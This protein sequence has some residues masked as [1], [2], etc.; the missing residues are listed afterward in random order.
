MSRAVIVVRT[1]NR[2]EI[3][4]RCLAAL[5]EGC[6][7]ARNAHWL[8]LDDSSPDGCDPTREVAR[9]WRLFG[10]RLAYVDKAVEAEIA[11]SLP[12]ALRGSFTQLAARS[13]S[14]RCEGGRNLGLLAGL[15]L[16]PEVV[17]FV[18]DDMVHRHQASCFLHWCANSQHADSFVAAPRKHGIRDMNY[19]NRLSRILEL[20]DWAQFVSSIGI[21]SDSE[22]WY[23][24]RNPFWKC[25]NDAGDQGS[26]TLSERGVVSGQFIALRNNGGEWLPFPSEYNSDLNWSLLQSACLGTA[27]LKVGGVDVKHMPPRLGHP[28][29]ESIL[30]EFVGTAIAR[31]IG[32]T[33]PRGEAAMDTLGARLPE[34]LESELKRELFL[35]LKVEGVILSRMRTCSDG[36]AASKTL[37]QLQTALA[38][39]GEGLRFINSSQLAAS[40][41]H[42]FAAR[43][44]MFQELRRDAE[45]QNRLRRILSAVGA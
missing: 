3:L 2:P 26:I 15:S 25:R 19:L 40:W 34:V 12:A 11:D 18:D 39:V 41:L 42:D 37:R 27:F 22:A 28:Q 8:V 16:D 32:Q 35:L 13:P 21:S 43:R 33:K 44:K 5:V 7:V 14:C 6:D 23:S 36:L 1:A 38:E 30:S 31:A 20:D 4:N 10:L 24:A 45:V 17:F 9:F 29:P